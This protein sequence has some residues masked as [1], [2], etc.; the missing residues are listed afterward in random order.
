MHRPIQTER[1]DMEPNPATLRDERFTANRLGV[2]VETLRTWRKRGVGPRYRKLGRCVRYS[3]ADLDAFVEAQPTGGGA[4]DALHGR[5][6]EQ[7]F[8]VYTVQPG[9]AGA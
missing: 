3:L 8:S 5:H 2:S 4:T 1:A 6:R 7:K 9:V